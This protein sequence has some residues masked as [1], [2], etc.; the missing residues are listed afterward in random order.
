MQ[1]E[2]L[3]VANLTIIEKFYIEAN[4]GA[5]SEKIAKIM[6]KA[7]TAEDIQ[8]Y[9]D[10]LPEK[11]HTAG[12][13]MAINTKKGVAIMTQTAAEISDEAKKSDPEIQKKLNSNKI[14]RIK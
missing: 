12:D 14:F 11:E 7:V 8:E 3:E 10:A 1:K 5:S 4:E 2:R 6:R 13:A 9:R